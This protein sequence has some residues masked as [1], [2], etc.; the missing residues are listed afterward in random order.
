MFLDA[1]ASLAPT[2]VRCPSVTLSDFQS[3][4]VSGCPT[5]KVEVRRPQFCFFFNFGSGCFWPEKL[6]D[7]KNFFDPKKLFWPKKSF[8]TRKTF[9]TQKKFLIRKTFLTR[10][11]FWHE[12]FFDPKLT[13]P[14]FFQTERTRWSACHPSFCEFVSEDSVWIFSLKI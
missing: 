13:Q 10:K 8:L 7:P 6:F 11:L 3:V 4:S 1:Q 14:K 5:W 12:N 2:H 9:L